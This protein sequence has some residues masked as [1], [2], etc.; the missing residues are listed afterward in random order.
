MAD[1]KVRNLEDWLVEAYKARAQ[2]AG[3]SLEEE[4]RRVLIEYDH[5][6]R[7]EVAL[8]IKDNLAQVR[9]KY[10]ILPDSID[11]IREDRDARG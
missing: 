1:V 2:S 6:I 4:L 11:L 9:A 8:L 5:C 3:R 7:K 10:G